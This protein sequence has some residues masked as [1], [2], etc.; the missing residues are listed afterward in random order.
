M[1]SKNPLL[2]RSLFVTALA[3]FLVTHVSAAE[4]ARQHLSLDL[5]W[6]F[7]LGDNW[8]D[9]I[10]YINAGRCSGA[11]AERFNDSYW[12]VVN[13][14]HDWAIELPFDRAA[15]G[16]HGFRAL[17]PAFPRNSIAWYR[18]TF[19]LPKEDAGKRIWLT[20]DG[21]YRDAN[22]CV[23]G[24]LVR[25]HEGGYYTFREDITDVVKFGG[26]TASAYG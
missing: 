3:A 19:E 11:A 16:G 14:P 25:H 6:R 12:R 23:N 15:D 24:Y 4:P 9:A 18:R 1:N 2:V 22:V 26:T 21:V 7:H 20:F 5:N 13:L 17:G 10:N 8:P